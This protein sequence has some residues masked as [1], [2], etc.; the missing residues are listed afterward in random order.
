VLASCGLLGSRIL[1]PEGAP[2]W[3]AAVAHLVYG[4]LYDFSE[5]AFCYLAH[6]RMM[7]DCGRQRATVSPNDDA[8]VL[9][10]IRQAADSFEHFRSPFDTFAKGGIR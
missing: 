5:E 9:L 3:A 6:I 2:R 1:Y 10:D 4:S 8:T 7:L